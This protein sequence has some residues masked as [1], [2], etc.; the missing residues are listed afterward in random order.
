[1]ATLNSGGVFLISLHDKSSYE[2]WI[3]K[4]SLPT[5]QHFVGTEGTAAWCLDQGIDCKTIS[6]VF[7][8]NPRLEGKVK[9]LNPDL[10]TGIMAENPGDLPDGIPNVVGVAVDLTPYRRDGQFRP[11]KID[12]GGPSL[13]RAAAKSWKHVVV[14]SSPAAAEYHLNHLPPD[15]SQRRYLASM[16][17]KRTLQYDHSLLP[18][19]ENDRATELSIT[20]KKLGLR[21]TE[22]LRYG[23]N[24][25]QRASW[26]HDLFA[27]QD[28]PF[29]QLSGKRLSYTNC[30]D[31][32]AARRLAGPDDHLQVSIIKHTNPTGWARGRSPEPVIETAW[33]GDPKS[34]YGS[35]VGIN[36][37]VTATEVR[38][39]ENYFIVG[40]IAPDFTKDALKKLESWDS[41][42]VLQWKKDW[43]FQADNFVRSVSGG[44]LIQDNPPSLESSSQWETVGGVTVKPGEHEALKQMWRIVRWVNSN[45]AV[46]GTR[47]QVYGVGAGQQSRVDAVKLAADKYRAFHPGEGDPLVLAS[48]GFFPFP[49]NI[50]VAAGIDV[51]A[52][53]SP[54]GSRRDDEV[55]ETAQDHGIGMVF[56]GTRAFYH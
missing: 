1:M 36:Q 2:Q 3:Q 12:I 22:S 16:A 50:E 42:R 17:L 56:T 26:D 25:D 33:Q 7:G 14:V 40:V 20:R 30:L 18:E 11:E 34:A 55:L 13:L 24:P 19:L 41:T 46:L 35:M 43:G 9:S 21:R 53:V 52:I 54:G 29:N 47:D 38:A 10:Y 44:Y 23:D 4:I 45:A 37:T 49:D 5:N 32:E 27:E 28:L 48:D 15:Q 31:A 6:D 51:D 39:L 8:L